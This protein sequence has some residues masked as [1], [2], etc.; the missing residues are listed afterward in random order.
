M[1]IEMAVLIVLSAFLGD[2]LDKKYTDMSPFF[3]VA[4]SLFGVFLAL[5]N[6]FRKVNAMNKED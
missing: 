2:W 4:L 5:Y 1:G 3:T 6:V